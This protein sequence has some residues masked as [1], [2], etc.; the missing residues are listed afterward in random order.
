MFTLLCDYSM[1]VNCMAF[2]TEERKR[3]EEKTT[4]VFFTFFSPICEKNGKEREKKSSII[5]H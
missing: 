3:E 2:L 4:I 1:I 5:Q